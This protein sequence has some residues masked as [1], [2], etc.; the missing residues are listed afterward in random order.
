MSVGLYDRHTFDSGPTRPPVDLDLS[1]GA[2]VIG[3]KFHR[4]AESANELANHVDGPGGNDAP[5]AP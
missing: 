1:F 2:A 5:I 4:F 3:F